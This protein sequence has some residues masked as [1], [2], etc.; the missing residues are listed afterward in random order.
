M[1]H[2]Y[3]HVVSTISGKTLSAITKP[4]DCLSPLALTPS[5]TVMV[6]NLYYSNPQLLPVHGFG[7]LLPRSLPFE[8]NPERALGVVFDSDATIGQDEIPGT[9]LTVMLGGHWWDGWDTYPDEE[10]GSS[11]AKAILARHLGI[12][13]QPSAMKVGLQRDCIPQYTVGHAARMSDASKRLL[14]N[15]QGRLRIAGNS[16]TGVGLNDCVRAAKELA[17]LLQS[18]LQRSG[19]EYLAAGGEKYMRQ[20][21]G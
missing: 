11:M 15:F 7:Y 2:R 16:Y 12:T 19:L 9:K 17:T 1:N 13:E 20:K 5:V 10:E 6:V 3:S 14:D 4:A 18:G 21:R 8:Q